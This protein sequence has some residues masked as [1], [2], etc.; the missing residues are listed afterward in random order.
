[1]QMG[2]DPPDN[3][4]GRDGD[5]YFSVDGDDDSVSLEPSLMHISTSADPTEIYRFRP[6]KTLLNQHNELSRQ[7]LYLALPHEL[8][9]PAEDTYNVVWGGD[10]I[11][12]P[13]FLSYYLRSLVSSAISGHLAL[14]GHHLLLRDDEDFSATV[15]SMASRLAEERQQIYEETLT[16]LLSAAGPIDSYT[17]EGLLERLSPGTTHPMLLRA[18]DYQSSFFDL[19]GL[20]FAREYT[21]RNFARQFVK[22]FGKLAS[23]EWASTS[24]TKDFS[25]P[26]L[27]S[28]YADKHAGVCL[29]FDKAAILRLSEEISQRQGHRYDLKLSDVS[30]RSTKPK[31]EFFAKL[32]TLTVAEYERLHIRDGES[33]TKRISREEASSQVYWQDKLDFTTENLLTKQKYWEPE[34]EMRLYSITSLTPTGYY[35]NPGTRTIQYP[36]AAL[37]GIIFGLN[38]SRAD[39]DAIREIMAAKHTAAPLTHGF[40]FYNAESSTDGSIRKMIIPVWYEDFEYPLRPR[41]GF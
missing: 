10:E 18:S 39:R 20:E 22:R 19:F 38:T 17:L 16:A 14:P 27:W 9:D 35:T 34:Q 30:Y 25:N 24:F 3:K 2:S 36:I 11:I 4:T 31:V 23:M 28:A 37:K 1:M 21:P 26:F 40:E 29:I 32:P 33:S 12:W 41:E 6:A 8:N 13:N 5:I 15:D 7:T